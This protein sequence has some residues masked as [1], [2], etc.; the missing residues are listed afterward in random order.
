MQHIDKIYYNFRYIFKKF[1]LQY[2]KKIILKLIIIMDCRDDLL[3][4]RRRD[5]P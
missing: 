2:L 4:L 3:S 5:D 1:I